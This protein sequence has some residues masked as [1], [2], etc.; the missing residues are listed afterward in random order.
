MKVAP[1]LL[2]PI[3][4]SDT[5]GR[6]LAELFNHPDTDR[7]ITELTE[8]ADATMPTVLR[9]V[10]RL[11]SAGYLVERR[12]GRNRMIRVNRDHPLF[13]QLRDI[14]LYGYGP[15]PVLTDLINDLPKLDS[16]YIYG[17]WAARA[18]GEPGSDP[19]DIDLLLVGDIEPATTYDLARRATSV[20]RRDV[21]VS[22]VSRDRW[23]AEEDGFVK[24]VKSRPL[25]KLRLNGGQDGTLEP[26]QSGNR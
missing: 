15:R 20:L 11:L 21:N 2:S 22:V 18:S 10:E 26:G 12:V 3:L 7:T 17:S 6:V 9:D 25:V 16:A 14:V 1:P 24:T 8:R 5:Q 19:N 23:Q 4:R 13:S